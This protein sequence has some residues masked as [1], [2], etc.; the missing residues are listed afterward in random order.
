M[1]AAVGLLLAVML[2]SAA[3]GSAPAADGPGPEFPAFVGPVVDDADLLPPAQERQ[4]ARASAA[5]ER[6]VGPEFVIV[7]VPSLQGYPILEYSVELGR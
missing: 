5:L 4:L 2:A 3:C 7:T 6:E 1:N